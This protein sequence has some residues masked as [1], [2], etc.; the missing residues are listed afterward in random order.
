[1]NL[2]RDTWLAI[3]LTLVVTIAL[4]LSLL[5]LVSWWGGL[6]ALAIGGYYYYLHRAQRGELK[7]WQTAV[8]R[9]ARWGIIFGIVF[10]TGCRMYSSYRVSQFAEDCLKQKEA[11]QQ[12]ATT[13]TP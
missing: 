3:L 6:I 8:Y 1:M 11:I 12:P 4:L 13:Q 7:P 2:H 9:L 10:H 5:P